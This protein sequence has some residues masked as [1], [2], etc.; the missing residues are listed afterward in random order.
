MNVIDQSSAMKKHRASC[1]AEWFDK[2][3]ES[4]R[5][6]RESFCLDRAFWDADDPDRGISQ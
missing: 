1:G 5:N 6:T 3:A 4:I 2:G